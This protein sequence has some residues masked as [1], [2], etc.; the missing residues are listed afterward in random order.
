MLAA[1]RIFFA[2]ILIVA[3]PVQGYAL[4][5]MQNCGSFQQAESSWLP[6]AVVQM[7]GHPN[8]TSLHT[9][10]HTGHS[11]HADQSFQ[12]QPSHQ[13]HSAASD[14]AQ[15]HKC[16]LCASCCL[17]VAMT[18]PTPELVFLQLPHPSNKLIALPFSNHHPDGL[19]HPP[20]PFLASF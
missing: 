16:H 11:D 7:K 17:S 10:L 18:G 12:L 15:V 3:L 4:T 6:A 19:Y 2:W 20:R 5:S 14:E 9:S 1:I 8:Q 13:A